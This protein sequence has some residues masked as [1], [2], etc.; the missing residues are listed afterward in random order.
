VAE[1]WFH[2]EGDPV[3]LL[4]K[5]LSS[6]VK[7]CHQRGPLIRAVVDAAPMDERLEKVWTGFL[8][9]FDDA[10]AE[11]IEEHQAAGLIASFDAR[12]VAIA[13]NRMNVGV[14]VHHFGRR[15]RSQPEQVRQSITRTWI[16][17]LYGGSSAASES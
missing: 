9:V 17:T 2:G 5:S 1:P 4:E 15:P 6:L 8:K 16:S 12:P 3:S 7:V 11:R 10:V 13:L 14:M